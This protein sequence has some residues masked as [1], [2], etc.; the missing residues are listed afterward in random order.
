MISAPLGSPFS[1]RRY[2][3]TFHRPACVA[4]LLRKLR[5]FGL[6]FLGDTSFLQCFLL[7]VTVALLGAWT[8]AASTICPDIAK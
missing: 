1:N 8:I 3:A 4:V 6:P 2:P 7:I 5:R